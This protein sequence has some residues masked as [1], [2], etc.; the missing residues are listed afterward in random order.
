MSRSRKA[1]AAG[2][3]VLGVTLLFALTAAGGSTSGYGRVIQVHPGQL[4]DALQRA[5]NGDTLVVHPGRYRGTFTIDKRLRVVGAPGEHRP[6]IDG[7]CRANLTLAVRH[8]GVV[9]RHLEVVGA[10]E[11]FGSFPSEVDFRGVASGRAAELVVRDTCDAEY[12]INVFASREV[13]VVGNRG[14]GFS[15]SAVYI[16]GIAS[17]GDGALRVVAN[18]A[19]R[20]NRGIIVEDSAGGRIRVIGNSVHDN[21]S[22]GEGTP[23]GIFVRN[24][25]AVLFSGN[26]ALD[27]GSF[28][29]HL[30]AN[31]DRNRLFDNTA[32]RNPGGNFRDEGSGNCGSGNHPNAFSPCG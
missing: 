3:V 26:K 10:D 19:Y 6:V 28:G 14:L 9:L 31:S 32:R 20:N 13:E 15:D 27:N 11:G 4:R 21:S 1:A 17:T 7:A 24:S 16:G 23:A 8:D 30:D 5:A 29:I 2:A 22:P 12:G 25:D 18:D